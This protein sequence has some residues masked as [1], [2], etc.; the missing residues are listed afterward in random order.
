MIWSRRNRIRRFFFDVEISR[1]G[2]CWVWTA[3]TDRDGYG[4]IAVNGEQSQA[5]RVAWELANGPIPDGLCV[6][7]TCD[8]PP[9]VNPA[10]LW[11][12]TRADNTAD[13]M[14]KG[15]HLSHVG[16]NHPS[17]KL[18]DQAVRD[19]RASASLS[20][21]E[22]AAKHGVSERTVHRIWRGETWKH[23]K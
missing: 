12:G 4:H 6:L 3:A 22:V 20:C 16:T 7:H 18:N 14:A 9:C 19:I 2:H 11:I 1:V 5:H 13:M 8:N 15:R 21:A 23:V 17:A 10:H